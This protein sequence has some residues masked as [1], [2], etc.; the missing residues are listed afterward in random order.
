MKYCCSKCR[1]IFNENKIILSVAD[2]LV[3]YQEY[4][5][6]QTK[7]LVRNSD[8][9]LPFCIKCHLDMMTEINKELKKND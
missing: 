4:K 1:I 6:K 8:Y 3:G 2:W 5:T 7:C 9:I